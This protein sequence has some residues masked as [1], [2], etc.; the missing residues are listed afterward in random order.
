MIGF[1][2]VYFIEELV[3]A[4]LNPDQKQS[5][6]ETSLDKEDYKQK[7][8]HDFDRNSG[9]INVKIEKNVFAQNLVNETTEN[10]SKKDNRISVTINNRPTIKAMEQNKFLV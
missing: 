1:F 9:L 5:I 6:N 3:D 4:T 8:D 10:T 7:L 2:A